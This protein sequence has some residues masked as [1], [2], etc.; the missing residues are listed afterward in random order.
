[1]INCKLRYYKSFKELALDQYA[2]EKKGRKNSGLGDVNNNDDNNN[3]NIINFNNFNNK[4]INFNNNY[5]MT[6]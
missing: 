4:T 3:N 2:H 1:M 5:N 6:W